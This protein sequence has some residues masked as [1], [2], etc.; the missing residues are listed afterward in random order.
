MLEVQ[1]EVERVLEVQLQEVQEVLLG[2]PQPEEG[3]EGGEEV[4]VVVS[5]VHQRRV[6]R[7]LMR[8]KVMKKQLIS[9]RKG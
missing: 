9:L 2:E 6:K 3:G 7:N 8:R 1:L 5:L 4:V